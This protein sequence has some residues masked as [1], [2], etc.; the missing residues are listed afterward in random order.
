M[1]SVAIALPYI[2]LYLSAYSD[3][4]V[5]TPANVGHHLSQYPY[6]F[7]L[8]YPGATCRTCQTLKP[9]RS[10]HCPICKACIG[11]LDHHCIF[12]NNC[13][14]VG[15]QH[16]FILLL[17]STGLLTL[18]GGSLGVGLVADHIRARN[19]AWAL[20]PWRTELPRHDWLVLWSYGLSTRVGIGSVSMLALLTSP[21]VW[22]LLGY[23]L[24]NVWSGVTTNESLKWGDWQC[25]M[26]DGFAFKRRL[27]ARR[28]RDPRFEA[29][30]TRWPAEADQVLVRTLDG[31][32]P[33]ADDPALLGEGEWERVWKLRDVE[34]LYDLGLWDNLTDL[35]VPG[36]RFNNEE[37][38]T[39]EI[40]GRK[41]KR[42]QKR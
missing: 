15:N 23:N 30:W 2:F 39:A 36:Y 25:E 29:P 5:V 16:W 7:T 13:V 24:W 11:R 38:P 27:G 19:P 21:L 14:G 32:P 10:K 37:V 35:F 4:G 28:P 12:I 6:D 1:L 40:R 20:F 9:A 3:P 8:F 26:D 22:G 42:K 31:R 18:Y 17:A 41:R 34:N 33:P